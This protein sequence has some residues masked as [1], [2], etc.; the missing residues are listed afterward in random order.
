MKGNAEAM[1]KLDEH[2]VGVWFSKISSTSDWMLCL[3]ELEPDV[4]YEI[5]YRF[6]YYKSDK[7]FDSD[8]EK[9]WFRATCAGTRAYSIA[10]IRAMSAALTVIADGPLYEV[11]NDKGIEDFMRRFQDMPF[12]YVRQESKKGGGKNA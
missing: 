11:L 7:V 1:I 10:S 12:V 4:R 6:R 5:V 3:R 2:V 9:S 8:D